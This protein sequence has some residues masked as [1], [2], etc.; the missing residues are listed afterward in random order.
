MSILKKDYWKADK[1]IKAILLVAAIFIAWFILDNIFFDIKK[2]NKGEDKYLYVAYLLVDSTKVESNVK[3]STLNESGSYTDKMLDFVGT[4]VPVKK[5]GNYYVANFK[6]LNESAY[7]KITDYFTSFN[8]AY[9]EEVKDIKVDLDSYKVSIP[10]KYYEN[11]EYTKNEKILDSKSPVQIEFLSV[12]NEDDL[13]NSKIDLTISHFF[14]RKEKL[15]IKDG[16]DYIDVKLFNSPKNIKRDD[17]KI[18][19]NN[20]EYALSKSEYSYSNKTGILRLNIGRPIEVNNIKIKVRK[21]YALNFLDILRIESVEAATAPIVGTYSVSGGTLHVGDSEQVFMPYMYG[22]A[23]ATQPAPSSGYN[24]YCGGPI[25]DDFDCSQAASNFVTLSSISTAWNNYRSSSINTGTVPGAAYFAFRRKAYHCDIYAGQ[26]CSLVNFDY[27]NFGATHLTM[28]FNAGTDWLRGTCI[29][30]ISG[31][32]NTNLAFA[33]NFWVAEINA[34]EGT[35]TIEFESTA[36]SGGQRTGGHFKLVAKGDQP[37][38]N[39]KVVKTVSDGS[40]R[41]GYKYYLY[42]N[43]DCSGNPIAGP[44]YTNGQG[45]VTFSNLNNGN[46]CVREETSGGYAVRRVDN[47][48]TVTSLKP[49]YNGTQTDKIPAIVSGR[50]TTVA[51]DNS[52]PGNEDYCLNIKKYMQDDDGSLKELAGVPFTLYWYSSVYGSRSLGTSYTTSTGVASWR[53]N[54]RDLPC[55][56]GG[57]CY[58]HDFTVHEGLVSREAAWDRYLLTVGSTSPYL[59]AINGIG[60][61]GPHFNGVPYNSDIDGPSGYLC[62]NNFGLPCGGNWNPDPDF[63]GATM[64]KCSDTIITPTGQAVT[65]EANV[66]SEFV[67]T[68]VYFCLKVKKEDENG[69]SIDPSSFNDMI[70]E[71]S[72]N[73]KKIRT[74]VKYNPNLTPNDNG[75]LLSSINTKT[76]VVSFFIGDSDNT[77]V[78]TID[79]GFFNDTAICTEGHLCNGP[80]KL[81]PDIWE[82]RELAAPTG[83]TINDEKILQVRPIQMTAYQY[84]RDG[85][86][87]Y[88]RAREDCLNISDEDAGTTISSNNDNAAQTFSPYDYSNPLA[89]VDADESTSISSLTV[90]NSDASTKD[91]Y[92]I[93]NKRLLLQWFKK[94]TND[95]DTTPNDEA[96]LNGAKFVARRH[97]NNQYAL[98][99][100]SNGNGKID[101][102]DRQ[103][104]TDSNGVQKLC[105]SVSG[106]QASQPGSNQY[107][108]SGDVSVAQ[109]GSMSGEVCLSNV[110]VSK[111]DPDYIVT[112]VDSA[113]S[114]TF[115]SSKEKT[116][117]TVKFFESISDPKT[118]E[119]YSTEFEFLKKTT[120]YDDY[121]SEELSK[122][123]FSIY[124]QDASGNADGNPISLYVAGDG[125]YDYLRGTNQTTIL[126]V[127][128]S[129]LKFVV[130]HLPKGKYIVREMQ[131][132]TCEDSLDLETCV[133]YYIPTNNDQRFT[134]TNCTSDVATACGSGNYGRETANIINPP[135]EI[136]LTKTD[137]YH[138]YDQSDVAEEGNNV[139]SEFA[140]DKERSDFD[141][142]VFTLYDKDGNPL[143]LQFV[144]NHGDCT[145]DDS[146]A[147]YRYVRGGTVGST[148]LH[149]CGGHLRIN[150]LCRGRTYKVREE[151][152][153][154][155][156]VFVLENTPSTPIEKEYKVACNEGDTPEHRSETH[157]ILDKPTRVTFEKRD[158][159]YNYL[160]ADETTTFEVYKCPKT[161][162]CHPANYTTVEARE[163]AGMELVK[164]NPRGVIQ[165]DEEDPGLPVYKMMSYSDAQNRAKCINGNTS[166]C[167]ETEVHPYNGKLVFRYLASGYNYVLLETVAPKNYLLPDG[168][169]AETQFPVINTTVD[170]EEVNVPNQPTG[171]LIRKYDD[172]GNLLGGAKFR[173]YKV[174]EY[175]P[176]VKASKQSKQLLKFKTIKQGVYED[177]P[178]QDTSE[179]MT[180]E[181]SECNNTDSFTYLDYQRRLNFD[182]ILTSSGE[183]IKNVL[184]EGTALIQYLEYDNY[185][186]IEEV[187]APKGHSL[188]EGDAKYTLVHIGRNTTVIEDTE[189][190][191]I[192]YPTKF[193]FYKFDE[194]NN[195]LDGAKFKLQKLNDNKSYVTM[196]VRREESAES[197]YKVDETSEN[198]I[199]ETTGGKATVYYLEE[200]QYRIV[201]VE[202]APGKEL[203]KKRINVVTFYVDKNGKIIGENNNII[204]NKAPT[205]KKIVPPEAKANLIINIQTG[206]SVVKY[207]LLIAVLIAA[208]T[209]LMIFIKKRK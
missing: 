142:I 7:K 132:T 208:I 141:R 113:D 109:D 191:F 190:A 47:Q 81:I 61:S 175:N 5:E 107:V 83:Y 105:Y 75:K 162:E 32:N 78:S 29:D 98:I 77:G 129:D 16:K 205:E 33:I 57:G 92:V 71:A 69:D 143:K 157:L 95:P 63:T 169:K 209:G 206:Q 147:E 145:T 93:K 115:G 86:S 200:G 152:V 158:A 172:H 19:V 189:Q 28:N 97:D 91:K 104:I 180:C 160:I 171:L 120:V 201:E 4:N 161:G 72:H 136:E 80:D 13:S 85:K 70:F 54:D 179:V 14:N 112:E 184:K 177:R 174:T 181:G 166:N 17:L 59:Y 35:I 153:P 24:V 131:G 130:K 114:H 9:A 176:N 50:T 154:E 37:K 163:A 62:N 99:K 11:S 48:D 101:L 22:S 12:I 25:S 89:V 82:V 44:V 76:G 159:K 204:T 178:V 198:E 110:N 87:A 186:V 102:G 53:F 6:T 58:I 34:N 68:K 187:E 140:N 199:I 134:I 156:S 185:Y 31:Y 144:G 46:Y 194:Y 118:F 116:I 8:N 20:S 41:D 36:T 73:G 119:N 38:G 121:T 128:A 18:Y 56:L 30:H 155:N 90:N 103:A 196:K 49:Y 3:F 10:A 21:F 138:E 51:F 27:L 133:G 55:A 42:N 135:T 43:N 164:F 123:A 150:H 151:S 108:E 183:T 207:G 106:Y 167:Y 139:P 96:P 146:Y 197:L 66:M 149:T 127:R 94:A 52:T 74:G 15:E 60:N 195:P 165:G 84:D 88:E 1:I 100:D 188:P 111:E 148:E 39:I 124:R 125:I 2:E 192:N 168:I 170:V 65:P 23:V 182:D 203:P 67:N 79:K 40:G 137:F 126:H 26:T 64:P 117:T 193:T 173:V 45:E 202:A 122:I